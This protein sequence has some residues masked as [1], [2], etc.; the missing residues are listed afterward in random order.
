MVILAKLVRGVE[1][2]KENHVLTPKKGYLKQ[3]FTQWDFYDFCIWWWND[4]AG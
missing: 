2:I 4:N 1:F 3:A